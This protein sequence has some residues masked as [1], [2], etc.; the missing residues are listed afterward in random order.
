VVV[1]LV[2][3]VLVAFGAPVLLLVFAVVG[4]LLG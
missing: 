2:L 3:F 4:A 1:L